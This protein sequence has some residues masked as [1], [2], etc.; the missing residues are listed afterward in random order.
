M[1]NCSKTA[2][3][4]LRLLAQEGQ[5]S[6]IALNCSLAALR[7]L[8][9]LFT[10]AAAKFLTVFVIRIKAL[11]VAVVITVICMS[12]YA[13]IIL[14]YGNVFIALFFLIAIIFNEGLV[15]LRVHYRLLS[16]V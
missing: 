4:L 15:R 12:F 3:L 9:L 6:L 8:C 13:L 2:L 10:A 16:A 5:F 1:L 14:L 11:I 7:T